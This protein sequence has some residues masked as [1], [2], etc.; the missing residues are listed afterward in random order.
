MKKSRMKKL[1]KFVAFGMS[2]MMTVTYPMS[3][4]AD[5]KSGDGTDFILG[6]EITKEQLK[7][8]LLQDSELYPKGGFEFFV[9]QLDTEEGGDRQQLVIVRRGDCDSKAEV[10]FKAVDVSASYGEDYRLSVE[11]SDGKFMELEGK[12]S[13]LSDLNMDNA[14]II[15]AESRTQ[16]TDTDDIS[17]EETGQPAESEKAS[18]GTALE[19]AKNTYLGT[20]SGNLNWQQLDKAQELEEAEKKAQYNEAYNDFADGIKGTEYTF[21][22]EK[23]E[24]MKSIY[25]DTIDDDISESDEQVMFLLS[26]VSNG[27][28]AGTTTAYLNIKDND[29]AE[30]A[31]FAMDSSEITV[32][33]SAGKA[34]IVINRV[35]GNN[36]IA[37][38]IVG[39]GG[40]TA[41]AGVDYEQVQK[42]VVF[43]QGV[44]SQTVEIPLI[45][46]PGA[47]QTAKFQVALDANSSYVQEDHAITSVV[48]TNETS[49]EDS[50]EQSVAD[51]ASMNADAAQEWTD[52]RYVNESVNVSGAEGRWSGRKWMVS[53][54]D[55]STASSIEIRW[56]S[57]EGSYKKNFFHKTKHGRQSYVYVNNNR[58][59][60]Y[61]NGTFGW[62][63]T[64]CNLQDGDKVTD[65]SLQL[66]VRTCDG[67][68]NATTRVESIV[69][70]YPGY[71]YTISNTAYYD[72]STGYGNQYTEKIYTDD[73]DATKTDAA[74]HRYKDG[75]TISLGTAQL[76]V[77]GGAYSDRIVLHR[78][79]DRISVQNKF[80]TN[81]TSNGV[82]VKE[83]YS[84]NVYLAGYQLMLPNSKSWSEVI[85]P[86]N[87]KLSKS[88]IDT[89]K[90]YLHSGNEFV[91]RPV[92]RPYDAVV[93]F[94]NQDESKGSYAN[95]FKTDEVFRCTTL[96]TI[97]VRGVATQGNSVADFNLATIGNS[98]IRDAGL[99]ANELASRG[100]AEHNR[101]RG[102]K[103][104]YGTVDY[105]TW[106]QRDNSKIGMPAG[107][108]TKT[109]TL[110]N[111]ITF[112]PELYTYI[113]P[114]YSV[115][116][117]SVKVDP[118]NNNKD[119]G[120][121]IYTEGDNNSDT[122]VHEGNYQN[123]LTISG[124][125]LNDEYTLNALTD[126]NYKAYFKN[127][128]G[129]ENEDGRITTAE[130][131]V[132]SPYKFV[133]TASNGNAYTFRPIL[134][135]TLI[136]YG[137]VP[138][139]ENRYA[140]YIDGIVVLR[141]K[142]VFGNKETEK[143]INGAQ[144]S[145]A[146][147][148]TATVTDD[149][150]GGSEGKGGDGYFSL[151]SRE[152]VAGE[153]QTINI[154]YNNIY[155]TA[156]QAVNAAGK[157]VLDSYDTIAVNDAAAFVVNGDTASEINPNSISNGDKTYRLFVQTYS[158]NA[159]V[160]ATKAIFRFYRK[161]GS[162]IENTEKTV[163][164]SNGTFSVDFN[165]KTMKLAPGTSMTV[166]FY[167]QNGVGYFE[168]EMGFSMSESIGVLSLLSSF[169]FGG[170]EKAVEIIGTIDS[171]FNFGWDG[172]LDDAGF[173]SNS[174]DT[175]VKTIS[176]GYSFSKDK[177]LTEDDEKKKDAVKD[178]AKDAG[179]TSEKKANQKKAADDAVDKTG[180]EN[181]S[182]TDVSANASITMSFGLE[183]NLVKNEDKTSE[184]LGKWYFRDMMLSATVDGGV[185]ATVTYM[186]PI[187]IPVMV[188]INVG[189]SGAATFII[190]QNYNK[191]E[192]YVSQVLDTDAAKI[193]LFNFNMKN[194]DRAF[195]AYGIFNVSPYIDLAAGAGFEFLNLMIGGRADFDMN[196]YTRADQKNTGNVTF[197]AYVELK[198]LFFKKKW[199][200]AKKTLNMFGDSATVEAMSGNADYTY[201]SLGDMKADDRAYL[202]NR[203]EWLGDADMKAQ[204]VASDSGITESLL[205][206]GIN[207]NP[208]MK[209]QKLSNGKYLVVFLDDNTAEDSYNCTHVYYTVGDGTTWAEPKLVEND[210][211]TDDAPVIYDLGEKGIYVAWSSS[212][213]KL[214]DKDSVIDTLNS[215]NIHGA[216]FDENTEKFG[217]IDEI[218][219]TAP[220]TY[221][222]DGVAISDTTADVDPYISYDAVSNQM[223]MFYTKVEY[224]STSSD[225]QGL[226]GDVANAYSVIAYRVYDFGSGKWT[227]TYKDA[228]GMSE[229]YT[230]AWYGQRF[231]ELAPLA[232]VN[233]ELDE[234]GYWAK[235]PD[236]TP[237]ERTTYTAE[238]GN[239]YE[240]DPIVIESTAA[241]YNG[242]ALYA[243][244]L[245][246]DGNKKTENDR[247]IFMQIY[248]YSEDTFTHPIMVTTTGSVAESNIEFV[249]YGN[250][251]LLSYLADNT[252][253]SFDMSNAV[254]GLKSAE[255]N[256]STVYYIDKTAPQGDDVEGVTY[257]Y[258]PA[259]VVAGTKV[260]DGVSEIENDK[261]NDESIVDFKTKATDNFVYYIWTKTGT[262]VKKGIDENSEEALKA[263]NRV[264]ESQI[265]ISRYDV[266]GEFI[267]DPVQVTDEEGA[268]YGSLA[269]E[270]E[271][272]DAGNVKLLATKA[273][274]KIETME[275]KDESGNVIKSDIVTADTENKSLVSLEFSPV[276]TVKVQDEMINELTAGSESGAGFTLY[277]AGLQTLSNLKVTVKD[278][279]GKEIY[280]EDITDDNAIYGGRA[281]N[282]SFTVTPD[283]NAESYTYTYEV[284]DKTG[285]VL[286]E[287]KYDEEIPV[288]LDVTSFRAN[289]EERG[290]IRFMIEVTNN[291]RRNSGEY[292]VNIARKMNEAEDEYKN[293]TSVTTENLAPSQS[294]YYELVYD[295][296][297]YSDMFTTFIT[298]DAET[299][300]ATTYFKASAEGGE[301]AETELNMTASKEQR[302]RMSAIQKVNVYD[303][304]DSTVGT[305]YKMDKGDIT[306]FN[307]TVESLAYSG[308]RYAG[309]DDAD[310]YDKS[311]TAGLKVMYKSDNEDV[312]KVYDTG[313][314]EAG[315]EGTANVTAYVMPSDSEV[316][317]SPE[318]GSVVQDNFNTMPEEAMVL[319]T[320]SVV[321]GNGQ[322][323]TKD[324]SE[325]KVKLSN[326]TYNWNGQA[327]KPT[328]KVTD[329]KNTLELGKDYKVA[330][331]GNRKNVGTYKVTVKGMGNYTGTVT[332]SFK[333]TVSK[334]KTYKAGGYNYKVTKNYSGSKA[335][336]VTVVGA[337]SRNIKS[338]T[339]SDKVVI[340]GKTFNVTAIASSAFKNYKKAKSA[341]I[342]RNI[343]S[344]PLNTFYGCKNLKT[345]T[346]VSKNIKSVGTK[347]VY[348]TNSK[349]KI[350]V[351]SSKVNAYKKLFTKKTGFKSTMSVKK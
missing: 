301:S 49:T 32:D 248:N 149:K 190:D 102:K 167:D 148:T 99:S 82:Q 211:T 115:P 179:T 67:N 193:D 325:C 319:K 275:G 105:W 108:V 24:Y 165:P 294:G 233:E 204:S 50:S 46:Y 347:A 30:K 182:N 171:Q 92:Y 68:R 326:T 133:R 194:A 201:E 40:D 47:P 259:T 335:G 130:E 163:E 344:I 61:E 76:S 161:D 71:Q 117:V 328:V 218:T 257:Q 351:P 169:N 232:V 111:V 251:T 207:P 195:D 106:A 318:T 223:M 247:D 138:K 289:I 35:S 340:G 132:V 297:N 227:D 228:E 219:Y 153:N 253:Y 214:T 185:E 164:S 186:T 37:S 29:E 224:E 154:A 6:S 57:D 94:R 310:S 337:T 264:S 241:T 104:D 166:Q 291:G 230:K 12:A 101:G 188:R 81:K 96:D 288:I 77:N 180:K 19:S 74:G 110:G 13:P 127:F 243:Y 125:T 278:K 300:E 36:S 84:G 330:Y 85:P 197:S 159:G 7:N 308:S 239:V 33:R 158:K 348:G 229:D 234:N 88:F 304:T 322:P 141:D 3:A 54:I 236:M 126:D 279:D 285:K 11:E 269:F 226:V 283:D 276:S 129:D 346:I 114:V 103:T 342:G 175:T 302:L 210:G 191:D 122:K 66:E 272:G 80:T 293:I 280:T 231:L 222:E 263:D 41:Q 199:D 2:C 64:Y 176:F 38:V 43:A 51:D 329:G 58:T 144:V 107:T 306:Q 69:I 255:I 91:L 86:E 256:G 150:F 312:L 202:D 220:H 313:F 215:M 151:S 338:I 20:D 55:F 343:K 178:A 124:V 5:I 62:K 323:D 4:M 235:E 28:L 273:A 213:R 22:F 341:R 271:N 192:Y 75:N 281:H 70:H 244:V 324:I 282:V 79:T 245:D 131:Y 9:S 225:D 303:G 316:V 143:A 42:E 16:E 315:K 152:F 307:T 142:P 162:E 266:N 309:N 174:E 27:E 254:E 155:L 261:E 209:M 119:K 284:T 317:Y 332:K 116:T 238:D 200:I 274:T 140:G 128:T 52:T 252:I 83:G 18:N 187:G 296:D 345:L 205:R 15:G 334:G 10:D 262:V 45:D 26:N 157:Y 170:A 203:S 93:L 113:N 287:D 160:N 112:T 118:L 156:T 327:K 189:G 173:V 221:T 198:V 184:N 305:E 196:F 8:A 320:F 206:N 135:K 98:Y 59:L 299:L 17:Q 177:D 217:N 208:D 172:D 183:L 60:A 137:F 298:K 97:I 78:S 72:E 314:V 333:I 25:I 73:A 95:G 246:Y 331:S 65:G 258:T 147:M 212:D 249:R 56:K 134:D 270:V 292:K 21:T 268:N 240:Q 89:Y 48:L 63:T 349:L 39:T 290:K 168:H 14:A 181:K 121:V 216:F 87:I 350:I 237:Y 311:N 109:S 267:T 260:N 286:A 336:N 53:G 139:T 242:L 90:K 339:V 120:S 146:G 31:I 265:Y 250:T 1:K 321:V 23:G 277:N 136:Y 100:N 123:P 44:T 295:Y 145:V 34:E